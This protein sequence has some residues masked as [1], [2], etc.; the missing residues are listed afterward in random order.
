M[1]PQHVPKAEVY[2]CR[3]TAVGDSGGHILADEWTANYFSL[4]V[5]AQ[6]WCRFFRE[7]GA[8][9]LRSPFADVEFCYWARRRAQG[10]HAFDAPPGVWMYKW[11]QEAGAP[12][13]MARIERAIA[14]TVSHCMGV[15][16]RRVGGHHRFCDCV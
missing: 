8:D 10:W 16:E 14:P 15:R 4:C 13:H 5:S 7:T 3:T 1:T 12:R 2:E 11:R 9:N 6:L